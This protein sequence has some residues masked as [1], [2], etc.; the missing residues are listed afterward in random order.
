MANEAK[1]GS[2][3]ARL[4]ETVSDVSSLNDQ[5]EAV[6]GDPSR[7]PSSN[8]KRGKVSAAPIPWYSQA[9]FLLLDLH[10]WVR[11]CEA[12][13]RMAAQLPARERGGSSDNTGKALQ[14]I[15]AVAWKL[16]DRRIEDSC[17]WMERWC[18]KARMALGEVD[19]PQML[20]RQPGKPQPKCP[21]C[22][23]TTLRFWALK[24]EIRCIDSNCV[25]DSGKRPRA[26]MEIDRRGEWTILW[27][28]GISG[29]P[30]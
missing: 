21:F 16:D 4:Q 11:E 6:I 7:H 26:T 10:A 25:D 13:M 18:R 12:L 8:T 3:R 22:D 9:A 29:L 27:Q 28:D 1:P 14:S 17:R 20:P 15:I 2:V 23:H 19:H 24:G 30:V 5:L